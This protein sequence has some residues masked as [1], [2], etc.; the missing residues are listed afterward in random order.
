M[1]IL[2]IDPGLYRT[3]FAIIH[4][5]NNSPYLVKC[6]I[7]KPSKN[8]SFATSIKDIIQQIE[9]ILTKYNPDISVVE[10]SYVGINMRTAVICARTTGAIISHIAILG[11]QVIEMTP[12][13]VKKAVSGYGYC[14]KSDIARIVSKELNIREG[15]PH[16]VTD[17]CACALAYISEARWNT[18]NNDA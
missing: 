8:G 14:T 6:G 13:Q 4:N 10:V 3:G 1:K 11:Y 2:G 15:V 5:N 18:L 7:I 17:A 12:L 9:D 16:D